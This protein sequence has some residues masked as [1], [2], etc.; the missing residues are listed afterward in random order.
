MMPNATFFSSWV[1]LTIAFLRC[2]VTEAFCFPKIRD[3]RRGRTDFSQRRRW[4]PVSVSATTDSKSEETPPPHSAVLCVG[5]TLYDSLPDALFLGGAPTNVAVHLS[6]L[7]VPTAVASCVGNDQLG[8]EAIRR[9]GAR[10]VDTS[11]I[12]RHSEFSTGMVIATIDEVGDAKYEFDTPA[13]WDGLALTDELREAVENAKVIVIGT[14]ACRLGSSGDAIATSAETISTIRNLARYDTVV[15]DVNLRPPWYEAGDVLALCRG[16]E[17]TVGG[18]KE[19]ALLK[20]NDEELPVVESWCGINSNDNEALCGE[21]LKRRMAALGSALNACR[22]CVTR[23]ADGAALWCRDC[24]DGE[25]AFVEN[26]GYTCESEPGSDTVGAGDSFLAA[27]TRSL[28]LKNEPA[29]KALD[30]ACALGGFVACCRGAVPDHENAPY[31]LRNIFS[32][33]D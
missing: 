4:H 19:L 27:L 9:I 32:F 28:L 33:A 10:G 13:A 17:D 7:G 18:A 31:E 14:I 2:P 12:Q 30:R 21:N 26:T 23:G 20:L 15:M 6:S 25:E 5:E 8:Q 1:L 11:L 29:E 3:L 24:D 16:K 22:V